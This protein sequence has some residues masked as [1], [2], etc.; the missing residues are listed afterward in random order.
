MIFIS[1]FL[2]AG[3]FVVAQELEDATKASIATEQ[4]ADVAS[5]VAA[6]DLNDFNKSI[7][8]LFVSACYDCHSG[9]SVDGRLCADKLDPDLINGGDLAWWLEVYSVVSTG[10]MPPP[11][12]SKLSDGDRARIV[13]WLSTEIQAAE[14]HRKTDG[15]RSS[16]RRLTR[17]EYNYAMHDLLGVPWTFDRDLPAETSEEDAQTWASSTADI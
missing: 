10:E 16:F 2:M 13:E 17:Y 12:S 4:A 6:R 14:K 5:P 1:V 8:P 9:E 3:S 7:A 11:E 15:S